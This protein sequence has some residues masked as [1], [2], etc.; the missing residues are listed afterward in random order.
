MARVQDRHIVFLCHL[1]DGVEKRQEIL[2]GVDVLL[3]MGRQQNVFTFLQ[4]QP[5]MNVGCLNLRQVVMQHLCHRGSGHISAFLRKP[6]VCQIAPCVLRI[7][8]IDIGNDVHNTTISL[9]RQA[10]VLAAVTGLHVE[11]G[12]ME[13]LCANHA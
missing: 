10:L 3:A 13:P 7:S 12:N 4:A 9:L 8:H 5:F 1:I 11:D 2:L 6:S